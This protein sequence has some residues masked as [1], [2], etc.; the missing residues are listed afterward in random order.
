MSVF[1]KSFN[2]LQAFWKKKSKMKRLV[3]TK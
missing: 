3:V 1:N 2:S